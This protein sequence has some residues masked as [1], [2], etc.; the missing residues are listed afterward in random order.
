MANQRKAFDGCSIAHE[1][2][3]LVLQL[4]A[5]SVFQRFPYSKNFS[6]AVELWH[7]MNMPP[8]VLIEAANAFVLPPYRLKVVAECEGARFWNDSKATN[9]HAT[10][11]ALRSIDRPIVWIGGGRAKGGDIEAF[12]Q[13]VGTRIDIAI[14]YGEVAERLAKALKSFLEPVHIHKRLDHAI[15]A[16]AELA[17]KIPQANVLFSPGFASYDQFDSFAA[18]GK[19]FNDTVLSLKNAHKPN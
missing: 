2:A 1:V 7:L 17:A 13:Q 9:F 19:S 11:G 5:D 12:A 15:T 18:R 14:L 16:A 3:D 10:L 6:L 4:D 8:A